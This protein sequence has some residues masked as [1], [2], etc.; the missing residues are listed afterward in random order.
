MKNKILYHIFSSLLVRRLVNAFCEVVDGV[1][2]IFSLGFWHPNTSMN[3]LTFSTLKEIELKKRI[4]VLKTQNDNTP[5]EIVWVK[6]RE[7][8]VDGQ[9][10]FIQTKYFP[11]LTAFEQRLIEAKKRG[12]KICYLYSIRTI[13]SEDGEQELMIDFTL[14]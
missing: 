7:F 11:S 9:L 8:T 6:Q 12:A 13:K 10:F 1:C 14:G 5:V 2:G 3:W 4:E